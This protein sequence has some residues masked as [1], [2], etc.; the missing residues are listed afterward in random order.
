MYQIGSNEEKTVTIPIWT[1]TM[2][3]CGDL[4]Y[5]VKVDDKLSLPEFIVFDIV[6][7]VITIKT[8]DKTLDG[9]SYK[10]QVQGIIKLTNATFSTSFQLTFIDLAEDVDT[11]N[12]LS[13]IAEGGTTKISSKNQPLK[14]VVIK[15]TID[16]IITEINFNQTVTLKFNR[17]MYIPKNLT[18]FE[19]SKALSF[20]IIEGSTGNSIV[21][22]IKGWQVMSYKENIMV[23]KL[24]IDD[25]SALSLSKVSFSINIK[26]QEYD[27]LRIT[28]KVNSLFVDELKEQ[29]IPKNYLVSKPIPPQ[30]K[31]TCKHQE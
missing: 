27:K 1:Q 19:K 10:I 5:R 22:I 30:L 7:R 26:F 4:Q 3:G 2:Q 29:I 31:N 8:Q 13:Q 16:A 25:P 15:P 14:R 11:A 17:Q 24:L 21:N 6:N 18:V 23:I 20:T 12:T 28:F 9:K